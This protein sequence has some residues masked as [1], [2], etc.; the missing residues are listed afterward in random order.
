LA[1]ACISS[2]DR[3]GRG[4]QEGLCSNT[5]IDAALLCAL[6]RPGRHGARMSARNLNRMAARHAHAPGVALRF[7]RLS[8]GGSR[9]SVATSSI[10]ILIPLRGWDRRCA[11]GG[12][13]MAR[14]V[15]RSG[16]AQW[17]EPMMFDNGL[18]I[19]AL[20]AGKT[21]IIVERPEARRGGQWR[22]LL[23]PALAI[24]LA[25]KRLW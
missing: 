17:N 11:A 14:P 8:F 9:A 6:A 25:V 20:R 3:P 2:L 7:S 18:L 16:G 22:W 13:R 24:C 15:R 1:Q 10:L 21:G 19:L 12:R 5:R 4:A 23:L